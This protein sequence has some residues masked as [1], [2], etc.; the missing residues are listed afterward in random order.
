MISNREFFDR[1]P[2][3]AH[4]AAL[5]DRAL[6]LN[7]ATAEYLNRVVSGRALTIGGAWDGFAWGPTLESLTVLDLSSEML[8]AYSPPGAHGVR[9]D[10]FSSEFRAGSFDTIVLA[11]MLHHV[12]QGGWR[13]CQ[14]RVEEAIARTRCWLTPAGRLHVVELCPHPVWGPVQRG[15]LPL[16]R[17][18]LSRN[19]QPLVAMHTRA[20]YERVLRTQ[21]GSC[22]ARLITPDG[23]S[24]W[25]WWPVF[26]GVPWLRVPFGVYPK[27]HVFSAPEAA[28]RPS[29]RPSPGR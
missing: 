1:Q 26:M 23:F 24:N 21:F 2:S 7:L 4:Y 12:A 16:T 13:R 20:Y 17:W 11:L 27:V 25:T 22:E 18:F 14:E 10:L 3:A 6:P 9:G 5:R 19:G 8:R 28:G 15:L 29:R